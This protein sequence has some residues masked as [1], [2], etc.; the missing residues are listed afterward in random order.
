MMRRRTLSRRSR[1]TESRM[2]SIGRGEELCQGGIGHEGYAYDKE[3]NSVNKEWVNQVK[4][5]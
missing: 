2:V 4:N 5:G 1:P 3:K